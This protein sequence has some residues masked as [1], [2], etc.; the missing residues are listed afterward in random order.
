MVTDHA[1][2]KWLMSSTKMSGRL[3]HWVLELQEFDFEVRH[4]A[5]KANRNADALS[6]LLTIMPIQAVAVPTADDILEHQRA[7]PQLRAVMDYLS[8]PTSLSPPAEVTELLRDSGKVS[9]EGVSGM[10]YYTGRAGTR[11]ITTVR[12]L[13]AADRLDVVRASHSLP[14]SGHFGQSKTYDRVFIG[15]ECAAIST[16]SFARVKAVNFGRKFSRRKPVDSNSSAPPHRFKR[17]AS[18]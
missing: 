18:T 14:S 1:N 8:K 3:A 9:V 16:T 4:K 5:G 6:R 7:D 12:Y 11:G 13:A 10:L 15:E 2:L 17:L